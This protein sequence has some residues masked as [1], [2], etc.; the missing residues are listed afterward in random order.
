MKP[1]MLMVLDGW[2]VNRKKDGNAIEL[3]GI[4]NIKRLASVYP[5]TEL[6]AG[7]FAVGL[8]EGQMG[9]SE[10]GHLTLGAGRVLFQ[11][12]TRIGKAIEDGS[13]FS[14]PVLKEL[15][16]AAKDKDAALHLLGLVSDGGVHSHVEHLYAI[17][18]VAKD[19]GLKKVFIHA[20]MDGRDTPP[21]SGRLYM[22]RLT[23]KITEIGIGE[24]ATVSGRYYAMDR[25]KRWDRVKRAYEAIAEGKGVEAT[26]PVSAIEAS[27]S[28]GKTD[29]FIEP[30]VINKGGRSV[31]RVSDGDAV[32]FFNFRSDRARELTGVFTDEKFSGFER[33][34]PRPRCFATMTEYDPKL[35]LPALFS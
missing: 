8:P 21:E 23:K 9:N 11:E 29:E 3:S 17:L 24:V 15:I 5:Y 25:D 13:F 10:V 14:N 32:L 26:D 20:F 34:K 35:N 4:K 19:A 7:G 30:V 22:E 12:L 33:K 16:S 1:V 6:N 31:G 18:A 27:Y 2:G 28:N